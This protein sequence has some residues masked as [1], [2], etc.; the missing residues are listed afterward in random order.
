MKRW[1]FEKI[2]VFS[3]N[4]L[5]P[6]ARRRPGAVKSFQK[7]P[8][9]GRSRRLGPANSPLRPMRFPRGRRC[10]T[11]RRRCAGRTT[12]SPQA[13][14][15]RTR[16]RADASASAPSGAGRAADR[17]AGRVPPRGRRTAG[18][19]GPAAAA[20]APFSAAGART[21][22]PYAAPPH[23]TLRPRSRPRRPARRRWRASAGA[24]AARG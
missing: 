2:P 8:K 11:A 3:K 4:F 19:A 7:L 16:G 12:D 22:R 23:R 14:S 17:N 20:A 6:R 13:H 24:A 9:T 10:G 15:A 1:F 21:G 5:L 18:T